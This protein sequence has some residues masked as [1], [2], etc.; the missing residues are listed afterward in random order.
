MF[1]TAEAVR[2]VYKIAGFEKAA[3]SFSERIRGRAQQV[4]RALAEFHPIDDVRAAA[5]ALDKAKGD[6]AYYARMDS[7][8]SSP[9][10]YHLNPSHPDYPAHQIS[11]MSGARPEFNYNSPES[12]RRAESLLGGMREVFENNPA[13]LHD[14]EA[15]VTAAA[16]RLRRARLQLGAV[17]GSTGAVLGLGALGIRK[18]FTN[19][20]RT[21]AE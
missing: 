10:N 13:L 3:S 12:R 8:V 9:L 16:S 19:Q 20:H 6:H 17:V 1:K 18:H 21:A 4:H 11:Y 5:I 2:E 7:A 14:S 15:A